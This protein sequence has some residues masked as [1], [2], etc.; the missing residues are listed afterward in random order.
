MGNALDELARAASGTQHRHGHRPAQ[1]SGLVWTVGIFIAIAFAAAGAIGWRAYDTHSKRQLLE[2]YESRA[3]HLKAVSYLAGDQ[4][5][6]S[7][8]KWDE[9]DGLSSD[10]YAEL[11]ELRK[12]IGELRAEG[13][14]EAER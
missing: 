2:Q 1:G 10:E 12:R 5:G 4:V 11:L 13:Y 6:I 7:G 3:G 9:R 8:I 14:G